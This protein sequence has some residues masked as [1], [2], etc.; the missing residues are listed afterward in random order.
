MRDDTCIMCGVSKSDVRRL[1][2]MEMQFN[3]WGLEFSRLIIIEGLA[4]TAVQKHMKDE[5]LSDV[6]EEILGFIMDGKK[7]GTFYD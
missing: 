3:T 6:M 2:S 5:D 4:E 7:G 1:T